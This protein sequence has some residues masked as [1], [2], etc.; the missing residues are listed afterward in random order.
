MSFDLCFFNFCTFVG[1]EGG[2]T[3]STIKQ[4]DE[5]VLDDAVD[6]V[7]NDPLPRL[8]S[9]LDRSMREKPMP[10]PYP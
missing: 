2:G 10:L 9:E 7:A 8:Q 4:K 1:G 5:P 3:L 6:S